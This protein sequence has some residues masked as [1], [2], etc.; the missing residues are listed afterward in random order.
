MN[1]L[2]T[3]LV[4]GI[5]LF[6]LLL[7]GITAFLFASETRRDLTQDIF[8]NARSYAELTA[9]RISNDYNLYIPQ[10][11]FIY[12]NREIKDKFEKFEDLESVEII[13]YE[14]EILY[15]SITDNEKRYEGNAR[16]VDSIYKK[17]QVESK[18]P[19]AR[20]LNTNRTVYLKRNDEGE[21]V[22]VDR[23]ENNIAPLAPDER[24]DYLVQPASEE[25]SVVYHISYANLEKRVWQSVMRSMLMAIFGIGIGVFLAYF[26]AKTITQPLKKLTD[27]VGIIA[28]GDF[29]H[30]V[31]VKTKDEVSVLADAVNKM[32]AELDESTKALVYKERVAKELELASKIQKE[33]LPT[34]I[35][36]IQGIDISAGL[37]PAE[38]I[39]GDCY[40]FIK[41]D[42]ENLIMYLGDVTGHGVP[43]GI[44]V[45]I[46]NAL[47]YNYA[48][49]TDMVTLL[50][51][52]NRILKE[53]TSANMFITLVMM[54]WMAEQNKMSYVSAGH[55]QLIK[56]EAATGKVALLPSGGIALGMLPDISKIL[57]EID[58]EMAEGD[59][60]I[61]YSDGIPEAW[62]NTKEMYGMANLKRALSEY[63]SLANAHAIRNAIL[64]DVK[65]Y[66]GDY[67]QQDDITLLVLKRPGG[68]TIAPTVG[69]DLKRPE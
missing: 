1:S 19:S 46:A 9:E 20:T 58:V 2:K 22:Y 41:I 8:R 44:V 21:T 18:I 61:A 62:K 3:K 4:V 10:D 54:K 59:V 5:S 68:P 13:N 34:Q 15:D 23:S 14:G 42:E 30:R 69:I 33:L 48:G 38:E 67:K 51:Q 45:S 24:V 6:I 65:E 64:S 11:S 29:K 39:G 40:D 66:M 52:V 56:Y 47:I 57:K 37:I 28:K 26:F 35:P 63:G 55:E 50:T 60:V 32:A 49:D 31:D 17:E 12:F 27:G 43:S 53:K 16:T 7:F 36:K 25:L